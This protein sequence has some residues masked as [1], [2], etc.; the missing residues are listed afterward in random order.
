M[1]AQDHRLEGVEE[2]EVFVQAQEGGVQPVKRSANLVQPLLLGV[3]GQT[4]SGI[5]NEELLWT[6]P[7]RQGGF[8]RG[9]EV[10]DDELD[11]KL[12]AQPDTGI[13]GYALPSM[14]TAVGRQA[15]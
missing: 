11:T 12:C 8:G 5:V 3:V 15:R 1:D 10:K 7:Q 14:V 13:G 9:L 6:I 2:H 4:G